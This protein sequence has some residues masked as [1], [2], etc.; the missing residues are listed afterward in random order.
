MYFGKIEFSSFS[1]FFV[2]RFLR[3]I[4]LI[5]ASV[6]VL[7]ACGGSDEP[8]IVTD[9]VTPQIIFLFSPGG[10]GDMSYNDCILQGVQN[11]KKAHPEVDIF[12]YSPPSM[13]AAERIFSDWMKR[14]GS[15]IPVV[16][17]LASSDYEPMAGEYLED[18]RLA[19]NKR[20]LLFETR[21]RYP[22][23]NVTTFQISMDG[24]SFL[25]GVAARVCCPDE[26]CLVLLG[27][28]GDAPIESARD[29]F[30]DGLGDSG[31]DVEYLA[32]DW[33]GF[34]M[35]NATY[36]RMTEW[37]ADYGFIFPVAGGSNAGIYRYTR[38]FD[39][40]PLL[41]GMDIDQSG[42]STKITGSVVK[43]LDRLI[44]EYFTEWLISG[45]MPKPQI[46]G[47]DSGYADWVAAP[48]YEAEISEACREARALAERMER[49][50]HGL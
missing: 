14:P 19:P 4:M 7:T 47:L 3:H 11:F 46:Y 18:H 9:P 33:T 43:R 21:R 25:A 22:D 31:Y 41:A 32:G 38:E 39:E 2:L 40:A 48:G 6:P 42:L 27:S 12:M 49:E 36:R 1:G 26:K 35:A 30:I 13:E 28:S 24:A 37:A 50:Y 15:D 29:G 17:A 8:E 23:P 16:F 34:V 20:V 44:D 5:I 10:L 45:T